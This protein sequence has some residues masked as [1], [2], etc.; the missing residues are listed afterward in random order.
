MIH[1]ILAFIGWS[2]AAFLFMAAVAILT[3]RW[4]D[5]L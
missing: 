4:R 1:D 2:T 3:Y 5:T